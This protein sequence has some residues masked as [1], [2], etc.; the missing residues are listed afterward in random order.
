MTEAEILYDHEAFSSLVSVKKD[1]LGGALPD[2]LHTHLISLLERSE[3]IDRYRG[4]FFRYF[5]SYAFPKK[6]VKALGY[7]GKSGSAY[8]WKSNEILTAKGCSTN[9]GFGKWRGVFLKYSD[10]LYLVEYDT[11]NASTPVSSSIFYPS[12]RTRVDYLLGVQNGMPLRKGRQ[13]RASR[14]LLE[15]IGADIDLRSNLRQCGLFEEGDA[16][17]PEYVVDLL[18]SRTTQGAHIVNVDEP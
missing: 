7:I 1:T 14:V 15:Y 11:A 2:A 6:F 16:G 8:Y 18:N 13:I 12:Y 9:H 17:L 4:Y 5:P 3:N 10:R